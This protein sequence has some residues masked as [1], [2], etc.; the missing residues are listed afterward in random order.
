MSKAEE[1]P[2][3]IIVHAQARIEKHRRDS[4]LLTVRV[5]EAALDLSRD[6]L[7]E[8]ATPEEVIN[9]LGEYV[10]ARVRLVF[11]VRPLPANKVELERKLEE[12]HAQLLTA[13]KGIMQKRPGEEIIEP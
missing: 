10:D 5:R 1:L 3:A 4:C 9:A 7:R 8:L 12:A 2:E 6:R 13:L 11:A